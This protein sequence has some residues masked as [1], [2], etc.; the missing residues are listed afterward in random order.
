MGEKNSKPIDTQLVRSFFNYEDGCLSWAVNRGRAK[1]G[2]KAYINNEGYKVLKFNQIAYLEHRLI[3][4]WHGNDSVEFLDHI[5][6]NKLDNRIENLRPASQSQ[7]MQNAKKRI[8]NCSGVKGVHWSNT[9]NKWISVVFANGKPNY[10]GSFANLEDAKIN[11]NQFR[12]AHH[13]EFAN[14]G[15]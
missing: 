3:W 7:N 1:K 12:L 15:I 2:Q 5:N 4:A 11:T 10:V 8:D 6:G 13:K 9:K 14:F